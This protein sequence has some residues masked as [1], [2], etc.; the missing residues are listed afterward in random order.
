MT[1]EPEGPVHYQVSVTGRQAAAFFVALLA[2]LGLAFFFGMKT[3][4]AAKKAPDAVTRLAAAS[5][6][7]V[8]TLPPPERREESPRPAEPE[9][10]ALPERRMGFEDA[11]PR[12]TPRREV[13]A[14]EEAPGQGVTTS[15]PP[16]PTATR[17]RPTRTPA[18]TAEPTAET[19]QDGP[20][21]VQVAALSAANA[22]E[23]SARLKKAGFRP[24]VVAV[25]GKSGVFRVR[26]G[27]YPSRDQAEAAVR[28]LQKEK[29]AKAPSIV[30]P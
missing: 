19:K 13:R 17:P 4:A 8:P 12:E 18:P 1:E 30:A 16:E 9:P 27:P 20:F 5:D 29:W 14:A 22:D 2:A 28:R 26:V 15:R 25:P 23:L 3:G 6:L 11:A 7:P 24:D 10:T 21:Y